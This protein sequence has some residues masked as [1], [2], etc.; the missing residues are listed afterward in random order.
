M[1]DPSRMSPSPS[2]D[3]GDGEIEPEP[4]QPERTEL[5]DD[6]AIVETEAEHYIY[7]PPVD[8]NGHEAGSGVVCAGRRVLEPY[9]ERPDIGTFAI[10]VANLGGRRKKERTNDHITADVVVR[11]PAQVIVAQEVG[12]SSSTR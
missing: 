5:H 1:G 7:A 6:T 4:E 11:N 8:I 2:A 12:Q 10:Y 9:L 3:W